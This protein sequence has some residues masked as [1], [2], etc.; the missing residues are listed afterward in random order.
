[1]PFALKTYNA[2]ISACKRGRQL[3]RAEA[4]FQRMQE[5]GIPPTTVTYA[6][7]MSVYAR[8]CML[9]TSCRIQRAL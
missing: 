3:P 8:V 4:L 6:A 9:P 7:I 2:L 5:E 1:M